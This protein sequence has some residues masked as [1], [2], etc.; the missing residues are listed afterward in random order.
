MSFGSEELTNYSS[1]SKLGATTLTTKIF[2]IAWFRLLRSHADS[3][4]L[5][6]W[7][8]EGP[9]TSK[10]SILDIFWLILSLR[11][12]IAHPGEEMSTLETVIKHIFDDDEV[13]SMFKFLVDRS[14]ISKSQLARL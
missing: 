3:W 6:V 2:Y 7:V 9:A 11:I 14:K 12:D 8:K 5:L 10:K 13:E 1:E 4:L